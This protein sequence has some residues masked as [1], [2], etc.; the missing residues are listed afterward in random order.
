MSY[1]KNLIHPEVVAVAPNN[2]PTPVLS[3]SLSSRLPQSNR[4]TS[5]AYRP[6]SWLLLSAYPPE[7][8]PKGRAV[9][10]DQLHGGVQVPPCALTE[11]IWLRISCRWFRRTLMS[12][13]PD[14]P[15]SSTNSLFETWRSFP[16]LWQK[17][18]PHQLWF[19]LRC[20]HAGAVLPLAPE[21]YEREMG[22]TLVTLKKLSVSA[23]GWTLLVPLDAV[24]GKSVCS[25]NHISGSLEFQGR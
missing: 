3:V 17:Q 22:R 1:L 5:L 25:F 23:V 20:S 12:L 18:E 2:P 9:Q 16:N 15:A 14:A 10:W 24:C 6:Q 21:A 8:Q 7:N 4:R 19:N 11:T 13:D